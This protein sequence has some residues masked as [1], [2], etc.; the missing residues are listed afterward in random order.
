MPLFALANAGVSLQGLSFADP[1][2]A[3]VAIGVI[4]GLVVGKPLGIV[5]LTLLAAKLR[6]CELPAGITP[7]SLL[8][9]GCLGGIGFTMAI[10]IA[11]LAFAEPALLGAAKLAVLVA[12]LV[13]GTVGLIV[14]ASV[15]KKQGVNE[16][17][18]A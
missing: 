6:L 12:S 17:R 3:S 14:G 15:F 2:A 5:S 18:P 10:F 7:R 16:P 8:V 9:V 13:A 4:V 1:N 11:N